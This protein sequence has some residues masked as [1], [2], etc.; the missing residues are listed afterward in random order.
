MSRQDTI[1]EQWIQLEE[2][3]NYLLSSYGRVYSIPRKGTTGG[4]LSVIYNDQEKNCY[5]FY[6]IGGRKY[7]IHRLLGKYFVPNPDNKKLICHRDDNRLNWSLDNLYWGDHSNNNKDTWDNAKRVR[8]TWKFTTDTGEVVTTDNL[9]QWCRDVGLKLNNV[10][11]SIHH[12]NKVYTKPYSKEWNFTLD[13]GESVTTYNLNEWCE[14]RGLRRG[15]VEK[16]IR[17]G[18]VVYTKKDGRVKQVNNG[19][20]K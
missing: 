4:F 18:K 2:N 3:S 5:P 9:A 15:T 7:K 14:S 6:Q 11:Q 16:R 20:V 8:K 13:T 19:E 17:S 10:R 12:G 1:M